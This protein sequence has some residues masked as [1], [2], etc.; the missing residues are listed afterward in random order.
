VHII[1][2]SGPVTERELFERGRRR[3]ER[4]L[5]HACTLADNVLTEHGYLAGDDRARLDA[6]ERALYDPAGHTLIVARGG[7]GLTRL[8]P[9]LDPERA[10]RAPKLVIGFSDTSALL[11]WMITRAGMT[12][13]HGPSVQQLATLDDDSC[14]RLF[15]LAA[16]RDPG[17]LCADQGAVVRGGRVDGWLFVSNIELLRSLLG[18]PAMP[19]LAGAILALEEIGERPYRIDRALTQ[20]IT[21]GALR[22]VRGV[23]VGQLTSCTDPLRA[24]SHNTRPSADE[25]VI[26]RLSTLGVPIVTGFS[27]GHDP[28]RND[29]LPIGTRVELDADQAALS[30]LEPV[31]IRK[32]AQ[33]ADWS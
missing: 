13:I 16:G 8:L 28:R 12:A 17:V 31:T 24:N 6:L 20:L 26:E 7:Y 29:A 23:I 19:N 1:A 5:G 32:G 3:L 2:P 25:V 22:G 33:G 14:A 10:R 30:L 11:A 21:S 9:R 4:H 18:T 15:D 27:F